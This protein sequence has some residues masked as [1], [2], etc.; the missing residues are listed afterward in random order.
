MLGHINII[1]PSH[2]LRVGN[3]KVS[4]VSMASLSLADI[5]V[6]DWIEGED[7][8]GEGNVVRK[9]RYHKITD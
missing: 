3:V 9:I 6:S 7:N 2:P 5:E 8:Q 1:F 4:P